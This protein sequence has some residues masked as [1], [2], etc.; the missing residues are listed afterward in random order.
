MPQPAAASLRCVGGVRSP[1][2]CLFCMCPHVSSTFS[3][4]PVGSAPGKADPCSPSPRPN[5]EQ[6]MTCTCAIPASTRVTR[7]AQRRA[8]TQ[9]ESFPEI[10]LA[11]RPWGKREWV[12]QRG[13]FRGRVFIPKYW[14]HRGT[15]GSECCQWGQGGAAPPVILTL[16][17][18][19]NLQGPS[20]GPKHTKVSAL[21]ALA[22]QCKSGPRGSSE[23][24]KPRVSTR[25][26]KL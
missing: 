24:G 17:H 1:N 14:C 18:I 6:M 7:I 26:V 25:R 21:C 22:E 19:G 2:Q 9:S 16:T 15:G 20:R 13:R 11:G 8:V 5:T 10:G 4:Q 3:E 12:E 23:E